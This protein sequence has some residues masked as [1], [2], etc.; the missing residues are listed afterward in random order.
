MSTILIGVDDSARSEDAVEFG[1]RLASVS[2]GRVIVACAFP[3]DDVPHRPGDPSYRAEL[4][5]DAILIAH[6]MAGLLEGVPADRVQATTIGRKSPAHA[7]QDL[8]ES[9]D[10]SIVIVGSTHTG[11]AGRVLPGATAERLLH[12]APCP[13]AVV[14]NGYHDRTDAPV[15]R[16]GV[17]FSR[18]EESRAAVAGAVQ[19]AIALGATLEVIGVVPANLYEAPYVLGGPS[20]ATLREDTR[21]ELQSDLESIVTG[22]PAAVNGEPVLLEGDVA[23][24]LAERSEGVDLLVMGSRGYGPL[25]SVLVGGVSGRVTR[26]ARCPVIVVPRGVESP[27]GDL[28][29]AAAVV[30]A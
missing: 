18:S 19:A 26:E 3:Y 21:R 27:L 13:V 29:A 16:I 4:E 11:H 5:G 1:R 2:A 15:R 24:L 12:G 10:A 8:A 6:R 22:L 20:A 25:R 30:A 28:F 7:L 9:E 23:D 14:P 17:A